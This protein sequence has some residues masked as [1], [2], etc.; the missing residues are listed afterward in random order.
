MCHQL[1][2]YF[3]FVQQEKPRLLEP[4]DYEAVIEELEKIYGNDPL[5]DL[6]FFPS[7]DFS[8]SVLFSRHLSSGGLHRGNRRS[9]QTGVAVFPHRLR[10]LS[11]PPVTTLHHSH[12]IQVHIWQQI[13]SKGLL[14]L[15]DRSLRGTVADRV[16]SSPGPCL[17]PGGT[18]IRANVWVSNHCH[19]W[20]PRAL[21]PLHPQ[22]FLTASF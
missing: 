3:L 7:D 17:V 6:L 19:I 15:K 10:E 22:L 21:P 4:L 8:V 9:S 11:P 2:S 18:C 16:R 1:M 12:C 13:V 5:R 20:P 14:K